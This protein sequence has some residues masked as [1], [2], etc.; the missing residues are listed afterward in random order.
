[1]FRVAWEDH[2]SSAWAEAGAAARVRAPRAR[3]GTARNVDL[4]ISF[5]CV[6]PG[7]VPCAHIRCVHRRFGAGAPPD[8]CGRK[9]F[10]GARIGAPDRGAGPESWTAPDPSG[11]AADP[12]AARPVTNTWHGRTACVDSAAPVR[13]GTLR[14]RTVLARVADEALPPE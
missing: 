1:M 13:C 7:V 6:V 2:M 8:G 3:V 11:R 14:Y 4:R 10:S 5:S 12:S 9:V